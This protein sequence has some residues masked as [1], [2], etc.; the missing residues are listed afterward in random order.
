[1]KQN[2]FRY[3][4]F[5][6]YGF[7]AVLLVRN[8]LM[9]PNPIILIKTLMLL[10]IPIVVALIPVM[11]CKKFLFRAMV[12]SIS[13]RQ[14]ISL[15]VQ[16]TLA[17]VGLSLLYVVML[18]FILPMVR[19]VSPEVEP[20]TLFGVTQTGI[21]V[22]VEVVALLMLFAWFSR[23]VE[24]HMVWHQVK[25]ESRQLVRRALLYGNI[26]GYLLLALLFV[27]WASMILY[28]WPEWLWNRL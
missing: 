16:T 9:F 10:V 20:L 4:L 14:A 2:L 11:I 7:V 8:I 21:T 15:S 13:K 19:F 18:S 5:G 6:L 3:I 28:Q 27:I 17:S 24:Y 26:L 22:L 25:E 23:T 1:M 12:P